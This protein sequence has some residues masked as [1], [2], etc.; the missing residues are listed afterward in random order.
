MHGVQCTGMV[1]YQTVMRDGPITV[2]CELRCLG[3]KVMNQPAEFL[4]KLRRIMILRN[5][6]V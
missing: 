3:I 6:Y 5:K 2:V 4:V 1:G